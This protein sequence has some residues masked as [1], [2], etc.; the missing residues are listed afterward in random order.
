LIRKKFDY[1]LWIAIV[2]LLI[3]LIGAIP[4]IIVWINKTE[5]KG[6]LISNYV[7]IGTQ[8]VFVHKLSLFSK[9]NDFFLRDIKVYIKYPSKQ[10][11][12][13]TTVWL[14]R[15]NGLK[16]TT[17]ENGA[18]VDKTFIVDPSQYLIHFTV[19]PKNVTVVGYIS[20]STNYLKD[21]MFEYVKY[22]FIN[23]ENK[24]KI[25]IINSADIESNKLLYDDNVWKE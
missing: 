16:M 19:F 20:F 21:E 14:W 25:L 10:S 4:Q 24:K 13:P 2:G 22:E 15:T 6:K 23:F 17:K 7:I 18:I 3:A 1:Q 9:N 8:S 11:E 12:L 5:I